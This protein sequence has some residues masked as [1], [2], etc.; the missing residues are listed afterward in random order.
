MLGA[1][2]KVKKNEKKQKRKPCL[3]VFDLRHGLGWEGGNI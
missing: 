1:F 3:R 2:R